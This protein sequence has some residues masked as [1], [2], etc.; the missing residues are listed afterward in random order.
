MGQIKK[1]LI[2]KLR[3]TILM[4]MKFLLILKKIREKN[5]TSAIRGSVN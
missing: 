4:I 3:F 1:I 2:K 5:A